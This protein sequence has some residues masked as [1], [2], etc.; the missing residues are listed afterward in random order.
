MNRQR[1]RRNPKIRAWAQRMATL[2]SEIFQE[3]AKMPDADLRAVKASVSS[4]STTNCWAAEYD[5][6][7]ILNQAITLRERIGKAA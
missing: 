5:L 1:Y 3:V 6:R 4:M 7:D 2:Q